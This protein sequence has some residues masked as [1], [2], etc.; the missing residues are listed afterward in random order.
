MNWLNLPIQKQQELFK[1]LSF[2]TGIP[3]QITI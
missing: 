2:K 1:Q 3:P